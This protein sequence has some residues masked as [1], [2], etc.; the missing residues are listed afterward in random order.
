MESFKVCY[1]STEV[2]PFTG[3][4]VP[5]MLSQVL[6]IALKNLDQDI[7]LMMPKYKMINER[8]YVLREVIRL[9]EVELELQGKS[10][11]ANGKT[12][13]LPN[14][15]VHVYF[16]S[17]PGFFDRKGI[18]QDP[19]NGN[20][21][22]DN[23]QRFAAFCKGVL[24]TLKL[25]YWQP[26]I[27]HCSDWGSAFIPYFLQNDYAD[28]PFFSET[29]TVFTFHDFDKNGVFPLKD[30]KALHVPDEMLS[31]DGPFY[32]KGK[33]SLLKAGLTLADIIST[34]GEH[35]G[36]EILDGK[37]SLGGVEATILARKKDFAAITSGEDYSQWDPE[38]D[39]YIDCPYTAATLDDKAQNKAHLFETLEWDEEQLQRPLIAIYPAEAELDLLLEV[40]P[41]LIKTKARIALLPEKDYK[42]AKEVSEL[43][44]ANSDQVAWQPAADNKLCHQVMAGADIIINLG[45]E[46]L[47]STDH[48]RGMRYGTVPVASG[49][50]NFVD[51]VVEFDAESG[52]GSVFT[53]PKH[54]RAAIMKAVKTAIKAFDDKKLWARVQK[55]GMRAEY[56]WDTAGAR[57][58][59]LYEKAVKKR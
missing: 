29:R 9:R 1:V 18:Y 52:K 35:R 16:L 34:A 19:Q 25:L 53:F 37:L 6:P 17:V 55:N 44:E 45:R 30:L 59:K 50:G 42:N 3:I 24:E 14:S 39:K 15:K 28:D 13:F 2:S 20:P 51:T 26:D 40:L 22:K 5:G 32:L 46:G 47:I 23:A 21:F 7:R 38:N 31:E 36:K 43:A 33:A 12:A 27:I 10:M 56:S 58:L 54:S 48:L 4:N 8:K 57:Y 41:D 49:S 11:Q